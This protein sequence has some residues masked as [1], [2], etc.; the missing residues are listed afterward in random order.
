[1][2]T[3]VLAGLLATVLTYVVATLLVVP[4]LI[5]SSPTQLRASV[6][7]NLLVG[8]VGFLTRFWLTF[9]IGAVSGWIHGR[10]ATER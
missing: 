5:A 3:S 9:P 10:A 4:L 2:S 7:L 8:I 6:E 1:V